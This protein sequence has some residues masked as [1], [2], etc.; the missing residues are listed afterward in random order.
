M[1]AATNVVADLRVSERF[2]A[3]KRVFLR[4][5]YV[6]IAWYERETA[7][8]REA[9]RSTCWVHLTNLDVQF[10]ITNALFCETCESSFPR[11]QLCCR[12]FACCVLM[13]Y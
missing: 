8:M 6:V 1:L 4:C 5:V 13:I 7:P 9:D 2:G 12:V 3:D 11:N 10:W